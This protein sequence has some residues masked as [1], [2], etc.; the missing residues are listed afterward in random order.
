MAHTHHGMCR[1][2]AFMAPD[3]ARVLPA[4]FHGRTWAVHLHLKK[5]CS[6]PREKSVLDP[7]S[8]CQPCLHP[9][10]SIRRP[11]CAAPLLAGPAGVLAAHP[12]R[13]LC[14]GEQEDQP[15]PG[16]VARFFFA[17]FLNEPVHAPCL[18]D[19][20][21]GVRPRRP[22]RSGASGGPHTPLFS[23]FVTLPPHLVYL[24]QS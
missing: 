13:L 6:L 15:D 1:G 19:A 22:V 5:E 4:Y 10:C 9:L 11:T 3:D 16:A 23:A 17:F 18:P 24:H 21:L 20:S 8:R 14:Q 12:G 2:E 7:N